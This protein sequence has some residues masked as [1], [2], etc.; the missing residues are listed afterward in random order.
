LHP[1]IGGRINMETA[2]IIGSAFA[3]GGIRKGANSVGAPLLA[4]RC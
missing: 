3:L 1:R 2:L 4:V